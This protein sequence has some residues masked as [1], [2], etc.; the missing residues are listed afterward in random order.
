M[1]C[2]LYLC[3]VEM[4]ELPSSFSVKIGNKNKTVE[5]LNGDTINFLKA[6]GLQEISLTLVFPMIG[7][8]RTAEYYLAK[9]DKFKKDKKPTQLIFTRTTPDG[10]PLDD[11]NIKV[12]IEDYSKTE[13][14]T[15]PFEMTVSISLKEYIDYGT[16]KLT[17][18]K[19]KKN[20]K[21]QAVASVKKERETTNAPKAKTY[22]VKSGD[23]LW[24]ISAKYLGSGAKYMTIYNA[25]RNILSNPNIIKV[26][27]VLT[28]PG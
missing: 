9:F 1:A 17:I 13:D 6:K 25:N 28:I 26:G 21:T 4:P 14:A 12:S 2:H 16:Q 23:T 27:Q 22:T 15:K 5:L 24:A 3:G 8:G 7:T 19:V 11:T 10:K 20:G 18:K